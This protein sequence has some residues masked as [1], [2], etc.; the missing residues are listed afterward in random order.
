MSQ[1][2]QGIDHRP[3]PFIHDRCP[4]CDVEGEEIVGQDEVVLVCREEG[5]RVFTFA[6]YYA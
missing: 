1:E 2:Q 6:R 4:L 5:C 3:G